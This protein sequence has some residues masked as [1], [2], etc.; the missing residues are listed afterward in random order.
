[1]HIGFVNYCITVDTPIDRQLGT[2]E[3][4]DVRKEFRRFEKRRKNN[5]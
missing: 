3:M 4:E 5:S 1:M 2:L